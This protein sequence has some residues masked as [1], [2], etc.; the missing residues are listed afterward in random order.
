VIFPTS[1]ARQGVA[2]R[3][4]GGAPDVPGKGWFRKG[5]PAPPCLHR[6]LTVAVAA[7][8]CA[9]CG[10]GTQT[11]APR[12]ATSG[13]TP[14]AATAVECAPLKA[15]APSIEECPP[16]NLALDRPATS[17]GAGVAEADAAQAAEGVARS[18]AIYNWAINRADTGFIGAGLISY[19]TG[20]AV[21]IS[22]GEDLQFLQQARQA[23]ARYRIDPPL[24]LVAARAV[25]ESAAMRGQALPHGLVPGPMALVL[26]FQGPYRAYIGDRLVRSDPSNFVARVV[27][28]GELRSDADL[29]GPIWLWGGYVG[30]DQAWV[31]ELCRA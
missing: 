21:P 11:G 14:R 12:P 17:H 22:F 9:A 7:L 25:A 10:Q 3:G 2:K 20:T 31:Q 24:R 16:R 29:G 19:A 4:A 27:L 8:L 15:R 1:R 18:Y 30:C 28:F 5:G 13:G 26:T 23:S 6:L